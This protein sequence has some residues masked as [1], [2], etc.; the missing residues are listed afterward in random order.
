MKPCLSNQLS[1]D[2]FSLDPH[3]TTEQK[4]LK[5]ESST[6]PKKPKKRRLLH[7]P[8]SWTPQQ[9]IANRHR[10]RHD[11]QEDKKFRVHDTVWIRHDETG[12]VCKTSVERCV[13]GGY[14]LF[15]VVNP[16]DQ[17]L[18]YRSSEVFARKYQVL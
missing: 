18:F 11:V 3:S 7:R 14:Y 12:K 13:D 10:K 5:T 16:D 9:K 2:E 15:K 4:S 17:V 6:L 1:L 8:R